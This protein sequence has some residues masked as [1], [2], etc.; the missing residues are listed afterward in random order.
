MRIKIPT[1]N[2]LFQAIGFMAL[3]KKINP[4]SKQ[5]DDTGFGNN[6]SNYGGR[7]INRDGTFNI[8]KVG[9]PF[10]ERF[11]IYHTMLNLPR[12]KFICVILLFYFTANLLYTLIYLLLGTDQFTGMIA[13][14][15]WQKVK[16]VFSF[17]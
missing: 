12:W 1:V 10:W 6:A 3:L 9:I 4:F 5:N 13:T 2:L 16:E 17:S 11:S 8:D 15:E 7:F 14:T